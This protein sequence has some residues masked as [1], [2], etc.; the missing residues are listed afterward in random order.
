M[1]STI[2]DTIKVF[3]HAHNDLLQE[4][5]LT[6]DRLAEIDAALASLTKNLPAPI[7]SASAVPAVV[8]SGPGRPIGK[9]K[10]SWSPNRGAVSAALRE[11]LAGG[12]KTKAKIIE[13]MAKEGI[14]VPPGKSLRQLIDTVIYSKYYTRKGDTFALA[15][16]A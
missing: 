4:R 3:T 12:P 14:K 10:S 7:R 8:P 2:K 13:Y 16:A 9:G 5:K 6:V 1:K 15:K 11:C